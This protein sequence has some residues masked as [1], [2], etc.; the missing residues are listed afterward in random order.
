MRTPNPSVITASAAKLL[1][2]KVIN[3]TTIGIK[4]TPCATVRCDRNDFY[5][6]TKMYF[7]KS[8]DF[9]AIDENAQCQLGDTVL[10]RAIPK[11]KDTQSHYKHSVD[12]IVFKYGNV[13]D[14]ITGK[15]V[16]EK[17]FVDES[18]LRNQEWFVLIKK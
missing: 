8:T 18:L 17:E 10:I 16:L 15:R 11:L 14:P 2:G 3:M 1:M 5:G 4:R 13:I 9:L 7:V 12:K 6:H